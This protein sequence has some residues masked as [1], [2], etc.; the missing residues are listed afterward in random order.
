MDPVDLFL[1]ARC[2]LMFVIGTEGV[3]G[4]CPSC[5]RKFDIP[6]APVYVA[7]RAVPVNQ[8]WS[9]AAVGLMDQSVRRGLDVLS[10]GERC[11]HGFISYRLCTACNGDGLTSSPH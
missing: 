7:G 4:R 1:C 2:R 9:D 3:P 8:V 5:R 11:E 6:R 10:L